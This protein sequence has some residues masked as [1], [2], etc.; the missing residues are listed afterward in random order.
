MKTLYSRETPKLL[1]GMHDKLNV[2]VGDHE[3]R[4][5]PELVRSGWRWR[6]PW[7]SERAWNEWEA[8]DSDKGQKEFDESSDEVSADDNNSQGQQDELGTVGEFCLWC[9]VAIWKGGAGRGGGGELPYKK[10]RDAR[11]LA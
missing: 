3:C 6:T 8:S 7:K 5:T 10:G 1:R 4:M 9:N 11:C 2:T